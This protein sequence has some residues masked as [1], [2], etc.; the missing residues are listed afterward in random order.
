MVRSFKMYNISSNTMVLLQ[1]NFLIQGL[2][3]LTEREKDELLNRK[4]LNGSL[5]LT[6]Y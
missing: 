3:I 1:C 5:F 2:L 4:R 6:W